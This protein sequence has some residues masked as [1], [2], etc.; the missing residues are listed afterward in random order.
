MNTKCKHYL[1]IL[2]LLLMHTAL[3]PPSQGTLVDKVIAEVGDQILLQSEL[4]TAYQQYLRQG[5][6]EAPDLK[7]KIL[8]YMLLNK[9]L[10]TQ[11]NR[12]G[13]TVGKEEMEQAISQRMRYLVAQAGSEE[14]LAQHFGKSTQEIK[15]ELRSSLK[16]QLLLEKM[17][18]QIIRNISVTPQEVK[19]FFE[20]L[21]AHELPYYPAEVEVR[22][23]VHYPQLSQQEKNRLIE[24]LNALKTRIQNGE[25]FEALAQEYSQDPGSAAQRGELGFWRLGELAPAYE[26]AALVLQPGEISAP[27]ETQFG[28]HLIQLI[29]RKKDEYNSRHILLKPSPEALDVEAAKTHL[30][31]LRKALLEGPITFEEAAMS[32]SEDSFTASNGGLLTGQGR[33]TR[34]P[35]EDLPPDIFFAIDQLIPGAISE[36]T[37]FTTPDNREAVRILFLKDKTAPHQANLAQDYEKIQQML[38]DEKKT[39]ALQE[40]FERSKASIF[41]KVAPEYQG[42][43]I[44]R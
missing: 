6:E 39:T 27:V 29:E 4:E 9:V 28:F 26:A 42:C 40:W 33:G 22:Q 37:A 1:A 31:Q 5:G 34:M 35:I 19:E 44:L 21:P 41:I 38:I 8:E 2:C 20:G 23:I 13:V 3:V 14:K 16:D 24:Q 7:C 30:A 25:S 18:S 32:D 10:L 12:E 11:A 36:P 17:R 15:S 43:T